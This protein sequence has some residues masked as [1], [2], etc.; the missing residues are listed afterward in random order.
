[1]SRHRVAFSFSRIITIAVLLLFLVISVA[2]FLLV[3]SAAFKTKADLV[4]NVLDRRKRFTEN[5]RKA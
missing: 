3:W 1:M 2:P 5:I 4:T